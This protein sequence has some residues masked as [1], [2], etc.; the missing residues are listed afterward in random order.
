MP[1]RVVYGEG[2]LERLGEE[3]G[4]LGAKPLVVTG[5]R[6]SKEN[7]AL[8]RALEQLP[9]AYVFDEVDEDP[10]SDTVDHCAHLARE[11][12]CG[13]VVALGGGSVIDV[14]KAAAGLVHNIGVCSQFYGKGTFVNGAVPI[15]AVPTTAGSGSETTPYAVIVDTET[16]RKSTIGAEC[17]FPTVALLDPELTLTLPESVTTSTGLDALSQAMEGM[18][19][20]KSTPPGDVLALEVCRIVRCSLATAVKTPGDR[21]A[22]GL[23]LYAAML[24]GCV[25]AQSGTTLVHG[26]G[27][28]L[29]LECG[30]PHGLANALLLTPLFRF[31]AEHEPARVA[32]IAAALGQP[33][34]PEPASAREAVTRGVHELLHACGV[35]PAAR[36]H[37]VDEGPLEAFARE[38]AADPYR[39][40]NQPGEIDEAVI[41]QLYREAHD[42]ATA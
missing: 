22:R 25:I 15:V 40:R 1:T 27:Y 41:L 26:M 30:L 12:D 33:C 31:N 28:Y 8:D 23:M 36:D 4:A 37:G 17:L 24:S 34:A 32:A 6:S 18:V 9:G 42:G 19:S 29:T 38:V 2:V 14:A 11:H 35:S 39:F 10:T 21:Q 5:R 16:G 3:C 20:K 7:G 13:V